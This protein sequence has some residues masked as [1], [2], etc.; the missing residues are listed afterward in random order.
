[1]AAPLRDVG[2]PCFK[3]IAGDGPGESI[4][5]PKINY[6]IWAMRDAALKI[7]GAKNAPN[8]VHLYYIAEQQGSP[9]PVFMW[10][11]EQRKFYGWVPFKCLYIYNKLLA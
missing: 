7:W 5:V 4:S 2:Y 1:M 11:K 10:A 3:F 6:A 9:Y 8:H